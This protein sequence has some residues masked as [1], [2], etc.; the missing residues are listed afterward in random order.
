MQCAVTRK[1][2]AVLIADVVGYSRLMGRDDAGT[3]ARLRSVRTDVVDPAIASESGRIVRTAGDGLLAEFPSAVSA[4]RAAIRIQRD[5]AAQN[6]LINPD[7]RIQYRIGVN[8]GDII[9]D[10]DDIAGDG[11]NVAS[12]LETIAEP[13]GI[14][15]SGAVREQV[16][17][18]LDVDFVDAGKQRLKNIARPLH[19]YRIVDKSRADQSQAAQF[20]VRRLRLPLALAA[21][22]TAAIAWYGSMHWHGSQNSPEES[23]SG[24]PLMSLVVVSALP[25]DAHAEDKDVSERVL[26]AVTTSLQRNMRA[27]LVVSHGLAVKSQSNAGD[28]RLIGKDLNVRYIVEAAARPAN[29]RV[30]ATATVV[31]AVTGAELWTDQVN[32]S[33]TSETAVQQLAGALA[34]RLIPV[35]GLAEAKRVA[36]LPRSLRN[37]TDLLL[38]GDAVFM[39]ERSLQGALAARK[40]YEEALRADPASG[41][42]LIR[43]GGVLEMQLTEDPG[44]DRARLIKEVDDV[45]NRAIRADA[46]DPRT[47][48]LRQEALALQWQWPGALQAS[49]QALRIDPYSV[50]ALTD[51]GTLLIMV[52]RPAEAV[53]LL[54]QAIALDPNGFFSAKVLLLQC[55]ALLSLAAYDRAITECES[56]ITRGENWW[57]PHLLLTAA[58]AQKGDLARAKAEKDKVLADRPD[59]TISRYRAFQA[60]DNAAWREQTETYVIA[61][62]RKGGL[63]EQ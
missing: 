27:A 34:T 5:M 50:P 62:L 19:V 51:R 14:S 32:V 43:I 26:Q 24:P 53:A 63:P 45:S 49:D 60:S 48:L 46:H 16:H 22:L 58:Y 61:G 18:T 29:D 8:L 11:V 2:V 28:V 6:E 7:E 57:Y 21:A 23:D 10:G 52:G 3:H 42:A 31:D 36:K 56:S 17:Q 33:G 15:I 47:W 41:P 39:Q 38:R 1:L 12:R 37:A 9:I 54:D 13:G 4:L 59:L 55:R 20:R 40:F 30:V 35:I 44:A 25:L